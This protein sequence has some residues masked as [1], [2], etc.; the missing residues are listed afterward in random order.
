MLVGKIAALAALVGHW[1]ADLT[2]EAVDR[3]LT[4]EPD[5]TVLA[6]HLEGALKDW[7]KN[8][9]RGR[10]DNILQQFGERLTG[11]V[12]GQALKTLGRSPA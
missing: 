8:E 10:L 11:M 2:I 9:L 5:P 12:E 1:L 7:Q 6:S 3:R 4:G